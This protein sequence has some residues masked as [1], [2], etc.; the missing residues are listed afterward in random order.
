MLK[1]INGEQKMFNMYHNP[2]W[3]F[4]QVNP[5]NNSIKSWVLP[6]IILLK[7]TN[8]LQFF[9]LN[10]A[11]L[12]QFWTHRINASFPLVLYAFVC[13]AKPNNFVANI[14]TNTI[15]LLKSLKGIIGGLL[16]ETITVKL[17]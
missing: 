8:C 3:E 13:V 11:I 1:L 12:T 2:N 7:L 15:H 16:F 10:T 14:F 6:Q 9:L 17:L 4:Q 5:Y